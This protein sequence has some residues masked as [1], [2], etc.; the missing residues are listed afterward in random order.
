MEN[1]KRFQKKSLNSEDYKGTEQGAKAVKGLFG[2]L[3]AVALLHYNKD[4]LK[5]LGSGVIDIAKEIV[6]KLGV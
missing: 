1:Q 4:N 2:G 6:G 3:G 5:A